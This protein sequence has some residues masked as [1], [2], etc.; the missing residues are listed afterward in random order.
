M[1]QEQDRVE[2]RATGEWRWNWNGGTGAFGGIRGEGILEAKVI[3]DPDGQSRRVVDYEGASW[4][5]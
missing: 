3:T 5:E 2:R 4:F 1:V